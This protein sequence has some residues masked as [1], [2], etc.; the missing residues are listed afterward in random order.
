MADDELPEVTTT[1]ELESYVTGLTAKTVLVLVGDAI[2]K[3]ESDGKWY[4]LQKG[5]TPQ[6]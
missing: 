3:R 1:R 5:M 6:Q 2:Y 4:R